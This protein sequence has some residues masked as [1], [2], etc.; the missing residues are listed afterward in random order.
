MN[1]LFTIALVLLGGSFSI[2]S[3]YLSHRL[4]LQDRALA[5]VHKSTNGRLDQL[6]ADK[7]ESEANAAQAQGELVGRKEAANEQAV[8]DARTVGDK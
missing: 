6:L 2:G 1:Y 7:S 4:T 5:E 8:H 3:V